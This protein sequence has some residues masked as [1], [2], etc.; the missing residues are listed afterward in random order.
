M[1]EQLG[2]R[3]VVDVNLQWRR[4]LC[5]TKY[6]TGRVARNRRWKTENGKRKT[7]NSQTWALL[8]T[9]TKQDDPVGP[10]RL[11]TSTDNSPS[12]TRDA[13]PPNN[14]HLPLTRRE[15]PQTASVLGLPCRLLPPRPTSGPRRRLGLGDTRR[16]PGC[17]GSHGGS[18]GGDPG[19]PTEIR[20]KSWRGLQR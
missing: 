16:R 4:G 8:I 15:K 18:S 19:A 9:G 17:V 10:P 1:G 2:K 6:T 13:T 11:N 12:V 5:L 7:E 14:I 20:R 3:T